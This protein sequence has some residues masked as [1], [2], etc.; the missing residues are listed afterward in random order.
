MTET[1]YLRVMGLNPMLDAILLIEVS[2]L[3]EC[4]SVPKK[5]T[6]AYINYKLDR[7]HCQQNGANVDN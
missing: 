5:H 7:N 1:L 3:P 6:E 4:H 2:V